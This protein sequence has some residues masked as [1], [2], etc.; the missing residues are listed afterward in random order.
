MVLTSDEEVEVLIEL[1]V[2]NVFL[3]WVTN[4]SDEDVSVISE[5]FTGLRT[6]EVEVVDDVEVDGGM[7]GLDDVNDGTWRV[8]G[9]V[10]TCD[11]GSN[12]GARDESNIS[13]KTGSGGLYV[14]VGTNSG[15]RRSSGGVMDTRERSGDVL[16][17]SRDSEAFG[18]FCEHCL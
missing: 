9:V 3:A 4:V 10:L 12:E 18:D 16:F 7:G 8:R 5:T 17:D 11:F 13:G 1:G 14:S 6:G 15:G 2:L